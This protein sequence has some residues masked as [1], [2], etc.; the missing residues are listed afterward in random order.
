L[1]VTARFSRVWERGG[2]QQAREALADRSVRLAEAGIVAAA[3]QI[4]YEVETLYVEAVF[5]DERRKL[6]C[7]RLETVASFQA[8]IDRRVEAARDPLLAS[9]RATSD[10][11]KAEADARQF[12]AQAA[13]VRAA[14]ASYWGG[15]DDVALTASFTTSANE[16]AEIDFAQL[17]SPELLRLEAEKEKVQAEV[18]VG[19]AAATPDVTWTVGARKFGF[20]EDLAVVGGVSIP[21]GNAA[22]SRA[23]VARSQ[24]E[25]RRLSAEQEALRQQVLREILGYRRASLSALDAIREI[26]A[27]LIPAA[28]TALALAREGYDRGAFSYFEIIDAQRVLTE[29]REARIDLL[30]TYTLNETALSRLMNTDGVLAETTP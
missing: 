12:A 3:F 5:L 21:L 23:S 18:E 20:D 13:D 25:V 9:A 19:R 6:A 4:R 11:L 17:Q 2:K 16:P 10:R 24:A 26:D 15:E 28:E 14:L 8:A 30:R 22:R 7:Q 29:L 1:Q 27:S